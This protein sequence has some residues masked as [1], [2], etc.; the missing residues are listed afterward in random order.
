LI[1]ITGPQGTDEE[2]GL[3]AETAGLYGGIPA[4]SAVLQWATATALY[5]LAGWEGCPVAVADV[6]I[7][8]TAG[9]PVYPLN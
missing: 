8:E 3:L 4:F 2:L 1:I 9:L 6:Q 5:C 7:A